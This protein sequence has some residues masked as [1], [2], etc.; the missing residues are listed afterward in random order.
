MS[1]IVSIMVVY[2]ILHIY[3]HFPGKSV[4]YHK[5]VK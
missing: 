4:A 3:L 5:N 1:G 2:A